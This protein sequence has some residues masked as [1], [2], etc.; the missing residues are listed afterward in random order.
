MAE[1]TEVVRRE[2]VQYLEECHVY[3]SMAL[4]PHILNFTRVLDNVNISHSS[5]NMKEGIN[6]IEK[7]GYLYKL[8][9][10]NLKAKL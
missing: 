1:I 4:A 5:V 3:Y 2:S 8:T 9:V 6:V 7:Y 10:F